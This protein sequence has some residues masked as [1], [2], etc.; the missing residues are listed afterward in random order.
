[1][2]SLQT[3]TGRRPRCHSKPLRETGGDKSHSQSS[4]GSHLSGSEP[5]LLMEGYNSPVGKIVCPFQSPA[6]R[7]QSHTVRA[8]TSRQSE[9]FISWSCEKKLAREEK[10]K[11]ESSF[12]VT[13]D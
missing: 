6:F 4:R 3:R 13:L 11:G 2:W 12:S 1:M 10:K 5:R 8:K 9:K 7:G